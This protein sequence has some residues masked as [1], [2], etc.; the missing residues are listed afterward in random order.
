L[1]SKLITAILNSRSEESNWLLRITLT[2]DATE[3]GDLIKRGT[4]KSSREIRSCDFARAFPHHYINNHHYPPPTLLYLKLQYKVCTSSLI[5]ATPYA[6]PIEI[7]FLQSEPLRSKASVQ[8]FKI[9]SDFFD[10]SALSDIVI[11]GQGDN[12]SDSRGTQDIALDIQV[13]NSTKYSC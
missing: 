4:S 13:V 1:R 10:D 3:S 6:T 9:P 8:S 12:A 2:T 7:P 11:G 5:S